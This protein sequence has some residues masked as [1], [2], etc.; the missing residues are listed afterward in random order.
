MNVDKASP[1]ARSGDTFIAYINDDTA[2]VGVVIGEDDGD[3]RGFKTLVLGH[4]KERRVS[5]STDVFAPPFQYTFPGYM[6]VQK[7]RVVPY[8][9][10]LEIA[11][12]KARDS[13][14]WKS[15]DGPCYTNLV[16]R[17]FRP[18]KLQELQYI[19]MARFILEGGNI[20]T[21]KSFGHW[22]DRDFLRLW[23]VLYRHFPEKVKLPPREYDDNNSNGFH[24]INLES[25]PP[26][27]VWAIRPTK[28]KK[29]PKRLSIY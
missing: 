24:A 7:R 1:S 3:G 6:S 4:M 5:S 9:F 16:A 14:W 2:I 22:S 11:L 29:D 17:H 18:Q 20:D 15:L 10:K 26:T 23:A 25:D 28:Y 21:Y 12:C 19:D 13:A 8:D 27:V